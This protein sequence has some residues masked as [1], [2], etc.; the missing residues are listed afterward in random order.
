MH[1]FKIIITPDAEADLYE[2]TKY[3]AYTLSAPD[4]AVKYARTIRNEIQKLAYTAMSFATV[5]PEPWHSQG[6]RKIIVKNYY[7]YYI[8][9][10]S[11]LTVH[12]L[13]IIYARRD[14]LK[15]LN[16]INL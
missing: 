5:E 16:K 12:I 15:I 10:E 9:N 8:P 2:I 1:V 14:Q 4:V 11:T 7:I 13:N 6:L 3:I